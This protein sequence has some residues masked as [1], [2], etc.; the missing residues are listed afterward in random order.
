M[1]QNKSKYEVIIAGGG[2]A[3][4]SA[5]LWC[6]DLGLDAILIEKESETGGQLLRIHN[7]VRNHLGAEGVNGRHLRDAFLRQLEN[8]KFQ[9]ITD[10]EVI[11]ADLGQRI[12]TLSNGAKYSGQAIIIATGVRRRKLN[13]PGEEEFFGKGIL[14]SGFKARDDVKGRDVLIVGGGDAALENALLLSETAG[15]VVVVHRRNEFTARREFV[16]KAKGSRNIDFIFNAQISEIRG[17]NGVESVEIRHRNSESRSRIKTNIVLIRIGVEPN[18]EIF[19]EQIDLDDA[20]Y[21]IVDANCLTSVP[22][23]YAVGDAANPIAPTISVA[24][25][26]GSAAAKAIFAE[27]I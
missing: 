24:V 1:T 8:Q 6:K 12:V 4:L 3:G 15:K 22:H 11:E 18:T 27:L 25:G 7:I 10:A 26:N 21:V 19:R 9:W 14:E 2:P 13:V 17:N 16:E 23:V 20:G 5:L